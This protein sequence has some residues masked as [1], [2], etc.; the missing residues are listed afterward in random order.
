MKK[1]KIQISVIGLI[2]QILLF[3]ILAVRLGYWYTTA[4]YFVVIASLFFIYVAFVDRDITLKR[5]CIQYFA[6]IIIAGLL[7]GLLTGLRS[8]DLG[9]LFLLSII[10]GALVATILYHIVHLVVPGGLTEFGVPVFFEFVLTFFSC[11]S[12]LMLFFIP[13]ILIHAV[14]IM[15][16]IFAVSLLAG[17]ALTTPLSQSTGV[18]AN[19]IKEWRSIDLHSSPRT[20][21]MRNLVAMFNN[22]LAQMKSSFGTLHDMS[23]E[24]KASSADLSSVAEQMSASLQEVSSTIE[25]IS[26]GA[27]EQS[28]SITSIAR[29]IEALNTLTSSIS[30]QV[31]MASVSSRRTTDS[32]QQ[33]M[34]ISQK[35]AN[36]SKEVFR[37]TQFIEDK[38]TELR[39][40]A[41]EIKKI[42]DIIADITEQTDLLALNAAIEAARVGEEGRGFAVVADEIR[43]FA[44]ET[45]R[46]SAVVEN[47]ISQIN[48]T[49][50]ELNMLLK[51]EREKVTESKELATQTQEQFTSI[52]K[53]VDLVSDMISRISQAAGHQSENTKELVTQ[54][55]QIAQVAADTASATAQ[56]SASVEEQTASMQELTSTA[57]VLASFT[58]KLDELLSK[59]KK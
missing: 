13:Y 57:Q 50:Q 17:F 11:S 4:K 27:Q 23:S 10:T 48:N 52:V 31:K 18:V 32:A 36:I 22:V 46:S 29:S 7:S 45:Q 20:P 25:Q 9:W 44:N 28:T 58:L 42:L 56:V 41:I 30:S 15:A 19:A 38:M 33:G 34:G 5:F 16:L 51:S 54:V 59:M 47:Y 21:I 35:E 8:G 3:S 1:Y 14:L 6:G 43:N 39:N 26:A 24:I 12:Y 55:E 40:Q 49:I 2:L 37:Q 53:A